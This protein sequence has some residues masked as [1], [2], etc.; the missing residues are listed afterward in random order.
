MTTSDELCDKVLNK[1]N[2]H[3]FKKVIMPVIVKKYSNYFK[4]FV[5]S[6]VSNFNIGHT[7]YQN[8]VRN[9]LGKTLQEVFGENIMVSK[10]DMVTTLNNAKKNLRDTLDLQFLES[11]GVVSAVTNVKKTLEWLLSKETLRTAIQVPNDKLIVY[12]Y[13]DAFPWMQWSKLFTGETS[14]RLKLVEPHNLMS[15]IVTVC[16]WL[17]PDDYQHVQSMGKA[18]FEQLADLKTLH[19]P[20]LDKEIELIVRGVADGAQRRSST[21]VSTATSTYPIPEALESADQLGDMTTVGKPLWTVADTVSA[22]REFT[23]WLGNKVD[24]S[25]N[26]REFVREHCGQTGRKNVTNTNIQYFYPAVMH[27][28]MR[29][30]ET[31]ARH[32]GEVCKSVFDCKKKWFKNLK[33]VARKVS[34]DTFDVKFDETSVSTFYEQ[35]REILT[36]TGFTGLVLDILCEFCTGVRQAM[37]LVRNTPSDLTGARYNAVARALLGFQFV[38]IFGTQSVT[39]TVKQ[40]VT[41]TGHYIDQAR[42]DGK[43]AGIPVTLSNFSDSIMETKHKDGKQGNLIYSGGRN[44]NNG[45][46][47]YQRQVLDQQ[48]VNEWMNVENREHHAWFIIF[49]CEESGKIEEGTG[50]IQRQR[51]SM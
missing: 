3:I 50:S 6:L 46:I 38:L 39:A 22:E 35:A 27:Q 33:V 21:G 11:S 30:T 32:I 49:L 17:G 12:H 24:N 14:I 28:C 4:Q 42:I 19:H 18:V 5:A 2:G 29:A 43:D 31:I 37:Q 23:E 8:I 36:A 10:N 45:R 13:T 16:S 41:Y 20:L 51:K 7:A 48:F 9:E 1:D 26:R 25:E 47:E 34:L 15:C 44:G 40:L